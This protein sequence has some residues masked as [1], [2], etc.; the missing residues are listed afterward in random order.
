KIDTGCPDA[1]GKRGCDGRSFLDVLLGRTG[2]HR[3]FVFAEHTARGIING[4]EAYGTRA[5]RD[6]R[7]KLIVNLEPDAEFQNGISSG[8]LLQSWRRKGEAGD[9]F[10]L[11]Q[12]VRYTKR[13]AVELYDL[14]ADPWELANVA[15]DPKNIDTVTRLRSRL[16]AWMR[17]QGDEGDKTER[18]AKEHQGAGGT[19]PAGQKKGNRQ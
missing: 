14:Q 19:K 17:Q 1:T 10:A 15:A 9:E 16:D 3:D 4:P 8:V 12:A 7:W 2:H 11:A 13:P 5:V 18:E 6:A